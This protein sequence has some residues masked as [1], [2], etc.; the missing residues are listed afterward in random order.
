MRVREVMTTD[1]V[2][3]EPTTPLRAVAA[4]L[5]ERRISGVPVV[6]NG[7]VLGVVSESDIVAKESG[8]EQEVPG[9]L[10][11]L[12]GRGRRSLV[13]ARTAS[14]AMSAPAV[15][16]ESWM[17]VAAASWLMVEHD[18]GRLPVADRGELVGIVTRSDLVRAFARSDEDIAR[19]IREEVLPSLSV[20]PNALTV[21]VEQGEVRL[22][23]EIAEAEEEP[24]TRAVRRVVG[25]VGVEDAPKASTRA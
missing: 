25:V 22:E 5:A 8:P 11:R 23:G 15:T 2:A 14:Q 12:F 21:A 24:V 16:V 1:V 20:P 3:V 7:A 13:D 18:V 17:S 6:L 10:G 19:E 4:L 9:L